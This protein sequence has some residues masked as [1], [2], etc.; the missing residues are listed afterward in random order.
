[1]ARQIAEAG[2]DTYVTGEVSHSMEPLIEELGINVV[3]GGHYGTET[4][5]LKALAAHLRREFRLET[6]FIALPTGA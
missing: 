1:M 3:F 2:Y 5:G 6:R 4:L